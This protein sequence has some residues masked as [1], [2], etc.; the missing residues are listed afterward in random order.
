MKITGEIW[1]GTGFPFF[2]PDKPNDDGG[3]NR[4]NPDGTFTRYLHDPN[5]P[6]SLIN[7]KV[8]AIFED[9]RGVF[10]V[11]TSGDGLHTMDREKGS[12]ER[13]LYNPAKPGELSRPPIKNGADHITFINE[14][15]SGAIWIGTY[16]AGINRYDP[17]TKKITHYQSANGFP[18]STCW[19]GCMS[20]DGVL[21]ISTEDSKLLYRV[22]PFHKTINSISTVNRAVN[23][24]E[25]KKR[26]LWVATDGNGLLKYDQYMNLIKQYKNDPS[27]PSS[28]KDNRVNLLFQN[29]EDTIWVG[30]VNGVRILN[31]VTQ[32]FSRY[33]DKENLKDSAVGGNFENI[34]QDKQGLMWFGRWGLGLIRYNPKDHSFKHF[35]S[36]VKDSTSISSNTIS[37]ILEDR[38]GILWVGSEGGINRLDRETGRFKHYLEGSNIQCL[39]EDSKGSLWTGTDKGLFRY[40]QNEDRFTGYFDP[41]AEINSFDITGIIED[42]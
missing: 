17:V 28:F 4:L 34:F 27:N 8:R 31:T 3:L 14:D 18:D 38:S 41:L 16:G 33:P 5:N 1:V 37:D 25:D 26:C 23:F 30:T 42:N 39:Y 7:N 20:S 9:S 35:L 32:Q 13:H 24:L 36:D 2:P 29:Q 12:F 15:S 21:W 6:H 22:D 40:N 11:G 10:W 19:N